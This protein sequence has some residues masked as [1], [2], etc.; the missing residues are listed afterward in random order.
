MIG[1]WKI[2]EEIQ[3]KKILKVEKFKSNKVKE[4]SS[5]SFNRH[6]L[7]LKKSELGMKTMNS[8]EEKAKKKEEKRSTWTSKR[9]ASK[10]VNRMLLWRSSGISVERIW[11]NLKI[12]IGYFAF[13]DFN[14]TNF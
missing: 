14:L 11:K 9:K 6:S 13:L 3:K 4:R 12:S 7:Q 2:K 1:K 5:L 10:A 8:K